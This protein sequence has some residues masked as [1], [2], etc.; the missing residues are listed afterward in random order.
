MN[1]AEGAG[2]ST[3]TPAPGPKVNTVLCREV[4][5]AGLDQLAAVGFVVDVGDRDGAVRHRLVD[6]GRPYLR[7]NLQARLR[8]RVDPHLDEVHAE[9]DLVADQLPRLFFGGRGIPARGVESAGVRESR[10]RGVGAGGVG[11]AGGFEQVGD[12]LG[13]IAADAARSGHAVVELRPE[14]LLD[15]LRSLAIVHVQVHQA[16]ND[17]LAGDVER[18]RAVGHGRRVPRAGAHDAPVADDDHR[19]GHRRRTG[20]V[21]QLRSD[22]R[23]CAGS[24]G[25]RA[26]AGGSAT[27]ENQGQSCCQ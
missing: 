7:R 21:N 9:R 23:E 15:L 10:P 16:G 3:G 2:S 11:A 17:R 26:F 6:D 14:L 5:Q 25:S 12:P 19:V 1:S 18:L 24:L 13:R 8:D 20:R 4:P 27:G 22:E